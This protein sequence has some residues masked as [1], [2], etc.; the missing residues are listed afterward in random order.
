V[1]TLDVAIDLDPR[2]PRLRRQ[3][4]HDSRNRA[5]SAVDALGA[6]A[7]PIR[8]LR[9]VVH[10]RRGRVFNQ[11]DLGM[12]TAL[13]ALGMLMAE[14]LS[15]GTTYDEDDGRTLYREE[16]RLDES[17][18]PGRWEPDDTGSTGQ[19][20]MIALRR[21]GLIRTYGWAFGLR[22]VLHVLQHQPV[23]VGTSWFESMYE[24]GPSGTL[25]VDPRSA[26]QGGHEYLVDGI[27]VEHRAVR[28]TN[29]WG[30]GW[31]HYG[32][33]WLGFADLDLL[34]RRGGDAVTGIR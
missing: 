33:A 9:T 34:L 25:I 24:P 16:T 26:D 8:Q 21:R 30:S 7:R 27:D 10:D 11:G 32:T 13:T 23:C 28:L 20:A 6:A 1:T 17:I 12:C 18:I 31:G 4:V 14:P 29:S 22:D 15:D 19:Y 3:K 2:D 5:Y